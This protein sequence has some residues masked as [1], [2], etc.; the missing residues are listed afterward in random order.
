MEESGRMTSATERRGAELGILK[1][2]D[3]RIER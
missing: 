2:K 1:V 3:R